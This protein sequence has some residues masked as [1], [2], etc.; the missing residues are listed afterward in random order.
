MDFGT[1]TMRAG[2]FLSNNSPAILTAAG[3]SG[4]LTTAVLTGKA[5]LKAAEIIRDAEATGGVSDDSR[6]VFKE[7][8]KLVWKEYLPAA[9]MGLLTIACIVGANRIGAKRLVAVT[10]AYSIVERT[11]EQYRDKVIQTIG[12]KREEAVRVAVAEN[13]MRERPLKTSQIILIAGENT[14]CFDTWS[15][16]YFTSDVETLKKAMNDT[17]YQINNNLSASLTDFWARVG[18]PRTA[19][20]DNIGWMSEKLLELDFTYTSAEDGRPCLA[21]S[22]NTTPFPEFDSLH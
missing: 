6:Q 8:V 22:F 3:V 15:G 14:L 19:E 20:S 13:Q 21:V 12:A 5:T 9:G 16:R 7:R 10:T 18:L 4:A 11:A 2:K 1:L 17:N